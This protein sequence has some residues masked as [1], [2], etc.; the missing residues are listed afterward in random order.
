MPSFGAHAPL[1]YYEVPTEG[2]ENR[3]HLGT[4]DCVIDEEFFFVRGCL[5]I[6]VI[7][8]VEPFSWGVWVSLSQANYLEWVKCYESEKR[9]HIGPF[10]G[11]LNAWIKPYP[12]TISLKTNVHLRDDG[13]RPFIELQSTDHPLAI[14]QR[15]GITV[16]RVA[17]LYAQMMH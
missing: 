15:M 16:E 17:E 1:S 4:D 12:D 2:R 11:W 14:E 13:I 6:P 5:E 3:C 8:E 10:F 9:S 7:G